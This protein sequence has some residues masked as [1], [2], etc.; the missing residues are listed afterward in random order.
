MTWRIGS[1]RLF[2]APNCTQPAKGILISSGY[3]AGL[4]PANAFD[5]QIGTYW[6]SSCT[7]C[8]TQQAWI[9]LSFTPQFPALR[10]AQIWQPLQTEWG[11]T[12]VLMQ[13][14]SGSSYTLGKFHGSWHNIAEFGGL[15]YGSWNHLHLMTVPSLSMWPPPKLVPAGT[16]WRIVNSKALERSWVVT[17]LRIYKQALLKNCTGLIDGIPIASGQAVG[18]PPSLALKESGTTAQP[19][20]A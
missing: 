6:E 18:F 1:L 9:G 20:G 14:W 16:M 10:C 19:S 2:T 8:Q 5:T 7:A 4:E 3:A 15:N 12:D 13:V 11:M 17:R